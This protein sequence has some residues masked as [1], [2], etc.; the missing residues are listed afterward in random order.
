MLLS[1]N[2]LS[3]LTGRDRRT[4]TLQLAELPYDDGDKNAHLYESEAALTAI[5]ATDSLDAARAKQALSQAS[6]NAVRE[7]DL[8][9][10]RIPIEVATQVVDE[11]LQALGATLKASKGKKLT[12]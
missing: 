10:K 7:E 6:L 9:K 4:I 1:I 3:E 12:P 11:I 5:Y 2:Q 8:R